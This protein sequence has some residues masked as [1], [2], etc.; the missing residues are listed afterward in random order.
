MRQSG[1]RTFESS[2]AS[3]G[4]AS[5][6]QQKAT[7]HQQQARLGPQK[8]R[9]HGV[10][11][12]SEQ[13]VNEMIARPTRHSTSNV[14]AALA[15]DGAEVVQRGQQRRIQLV[16]FLPRS[17]HSDTASTRPSRSTALCS[18][19]LREDERSR[20]LRQR[21][22]PQHRNAASEMNEDRGCRES[23]PARAASCRT[24]PSTA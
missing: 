5:Q 24:A 21:V 20:R 6:R 4:E 14:L 12:S 2:Q 19:G 15:R 18:A 13:V 17:N 10:M 1:R 11:V 22:E 3:G 23:E 9:Q 7:P 16:R 8:H